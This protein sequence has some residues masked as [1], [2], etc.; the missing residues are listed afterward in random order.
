MASTVRQNVV[1]PLGIMT[2]PNP[3]GQYPAGSLEA[4]DGVSMRAPGELQSLPAAS[5][6]TEAGSFPTMI[7]NKLYALDDGHVYAFKWPGTSGSWFVE[8]G[9][10]SSGNTMND[11]TVNLWGG[12]TTDL[13]YAGYICPIRSRE[14]MLVNSSRGVLVGDVMAPANATDRSLRPAGLPQVGTFGSLYYNGTG[15]LPPQTMVAYTAIGVREF[16]DGYVIKSVP[17]PG[18]I[19]WNNDATLNNQATIYIYFVPTAYKVGDFVDIYRTDGLNTNSADTD[20]GTTFK[21]IRRY[22]LTSTDIANGFF[23]V[24]DT[25]ACN[26]P[27]Y[28]TT[29]EELYTNPGIEGSLGA[30]RLPDNCKAAAVFKGYSFY[31]NITERPQL[32]LS[33]PAGWSDSITIASGTFFQTSGIGGRQGTGTITSGSPTITGIPAGQTTG[34]VPGQQWD[35]VSLDFTFGTKVLS[36]T[37]TTI[38][39]AA[40]ALRNNT[41]DGWAVVDVIEIDGV[42][43]II[44]SFAQLVS[45]LAGS[46]ELTA[47]DNA[48]NQSTIANANSECIV[49]P[50]DVS[51]ASQTITVRATNGANY[52]P[53]LPDISSTVATYS[54]TTTQNLMRWSKNNEPEHVPAKNEDKPGSAKLVQFVSTK[55]AL[56]IFCTDG[57]FRLS[58]DAGVWRVDVIDPKCVI[59]SPQCATSLHETVYAHTNYGFVSVTDAGVAPISLN[60]VVELLP[61]S[62]FADRSDMIVERDILNHEVIISLA[63]SNNEFIVYNTPND[64][65]TTVTAATIFPHGVT[66][67]A[68]RELPQ[69]GHTACPIFAATS[70]LGTGHQVIY[71]WE[72]D[73]VYVIPFVKYRQLYGNDPLSQKQWISATYLFNPA[74]AGKTI[75]TEISSFTSGTVTLRQ[76]FND[77]YGTCGVLRK[78]AIAPSI[79]PGFVGN[80]QESTVTRFRGVSLYLC[81]FTQQPWR[82]T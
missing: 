60:R 74:D 1:V 24:D 72:S 56:W 46:Y 12:G 4:A 18:Y 69:S 79:Q 57:V 45:G 10:I 27:F 42:P 65:F 13:F 38:T 47:S 5:N 29:G 11:V 3:Y 81:E 31:G 62:P 51:N 41:T 58:G 64:A 48:N 21:K 73:G 20:P 71:A 52:S 70:V 44:R 76:S 19:L 32:S 67:I 68:F 61:P 14:R 43:Y 59:C 77:A 35:G 17:A 78:Y 49:E 8:E 66:A 23:N 53:K 54:Q 75:V 55:D 9:Q 15:P 40:N 80:G 16:S 82:Q 39:M 36:V 6:E 28:T 50:V 26:A 34:V 30:N 33:V 2:T 25:A 63:A 7:V 22:T 37:S